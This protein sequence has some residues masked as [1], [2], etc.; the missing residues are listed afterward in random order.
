MLPLSEG[1]NKC[2][3]HNVMATICSKTLIPVNLTI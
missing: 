3:E 2:Q 1:V